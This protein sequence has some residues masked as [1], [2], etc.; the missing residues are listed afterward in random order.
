MN[1]NIINN[2]L[3]DNGYDLSSKDSNDI[4]VSINNN[5]VTIT[6]S[7]NNLIE[8]ADYI[9]SLALSNNEKDHIHIDD[10]TLLSS[11]SVELIIEKE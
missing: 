5:E 10:L 3:Q 8:L 2:Y 4:K 9:V 7:K 1:K 6:G 11:D